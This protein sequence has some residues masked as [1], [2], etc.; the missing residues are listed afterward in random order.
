MKFSL[1]IL[2]APQ[3]SPSVSA[4][5]KFAEAALAG[6]HEVFRVFFFHDAVQTGNSLSV[7]PQDQKNLSRAWQALAEAHNID[8]VLCVSSALRRGIVDER[9]SRRYHLGASNRLEGFELSGLGQWVDAMFQ[10]DRIVT[11]GG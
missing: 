8:L 1:L 2:G 5:L 10:S 6:G 9:E 7:M 4:A 11:F 3:S